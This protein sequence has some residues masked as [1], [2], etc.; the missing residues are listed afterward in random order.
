MPNMKSMFALGVMFLLVVSGC[1]AILPTAQLLSQVGVESQAE[2]PPMEETTATVVEATPTETPVEE[3]T[4]AATEEPTPLPTATATVEPTI[5]PAATVEPT[6]EPTVA[7]TEGISESMAMSETVALSDTASMSDTVTISE[8][9][10]MTESAEMTDG[11]AMTETVAL[12]EA[13]TLTESTPITES[14]ATTVTTAIDAVAVDTATVLVRSLR[15]RSGPGTIYEVVGGARQGETYPIVGQAEA[16]EWYQ[17]NHP[18]LGLVWLA[19]DVFTASEGDCAAIPAVDSVNAAGDTAA[20]AP[21]EADVTST[22][23]TL[24]PTP[25]PA[26]TAVT[27]EAPA[28]ET[29][30]E[31][32]PVEEATV[33]GEETGATDPFPADKGCLILQNQ[34]GPELTFT[35][36]GQDGAFTDTVKVMSDEDVHY[37]L[38]PGRYSVTVDAPPPW[39]DINKEFAVAAGDRFFFPI[40]PQ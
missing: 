25:V 19:G 18:Q 11:A 33:E 26:E 6:V 13:V 10:V 3:P 9:A 34:L 38:E 23:V 4:V 16:C 17:I 14:A 29:P 27:E 7:A 22:P 20:A 30:V 31:E 40:R 24:L 2:M 15:I 1:Q 8:T 36:T 32:A 5:E 28:E 39:L 21:A 35:F 37:C 12:T